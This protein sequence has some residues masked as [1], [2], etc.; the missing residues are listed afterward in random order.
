MA[1]ASSS[2]FALTNTRITV[3]GAESNLIFYNLVAHQALADV[4]SFTFI[5]RQPGGKASFASY[6]QFYQKYLAKEVTIHIGNTVSIKG[7]ITSI[8]CVEADE[9]GVHYEIKGKGLFAKLDQSPDCNIFL[10]KTIKDIFTALNTASL[11]LT[12]TPAN[13]AKLHYTVQY[14]QTTFEFFRMMAIRHGE[15]LYDSGKGISAWDLPK[16]EPQFRSRWIPI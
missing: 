16:R 2:G 8:T 10:K 1:S 15:W 12:L 6:V 5:W 11:S 14:N 7:I 3:E 9:L 13:A 4:N